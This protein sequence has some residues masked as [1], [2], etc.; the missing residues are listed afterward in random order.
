MKLNTLTA[1]SLSIALLSAC[2]ESAP[3]ELDETTRAQID[4]L[5]AQTVVSISNTVRDGLAAGQT[6]EQLA[7]VDSDAIKASTSLLVSRISA[8][9]ARA[10]FTAEVERR[11]DAVQTGLGAP[12]SEAG[13]LM[14]ETFAL[15]ATCKFGGA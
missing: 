3:T 14:N 9:G 1:A 13:A 12:D 11:L 2:S 8:P 4:C 6:P 10:S 15:A 7:N 5:A